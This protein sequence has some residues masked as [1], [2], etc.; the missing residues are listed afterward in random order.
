MDLCAALATPAKEEKGRLKDLEFRTFDAHDDVFAG[1]TFGLLNPNPTG[2]P[3]TF[4]GTCGNL[5][6]LVDN[7]AGFC[8]NGNGVFGI[9]MDTGFCA[10]GGG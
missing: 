2:L 6:F 3:L 4:F 7:D 10:S 5:R 9:G 8:D 1:G